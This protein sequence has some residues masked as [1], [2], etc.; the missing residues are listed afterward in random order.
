MYVLVQFTMLIESEEER[1][2]FWTRSIIHTDAA[3][4]DITNR[5]TIERPSYEEKK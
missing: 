3:E 2:V 4:A 5:K 1:R